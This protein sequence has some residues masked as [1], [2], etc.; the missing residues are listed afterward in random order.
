MP[1]FPINSRPNLPVYVH[2]D[3]DV[4]PDR[5]IEINYGLGLGE[6]IYVA[7]S[8]NN[9]TVVHCS[10]VTY[11]CWYKRNKMNLN[12]WKIQAILEFTDDLG[13]AVKVVCYPFGCKGYNFYT[14][15]IQYY[16][17]SVRY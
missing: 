2:A 5:I 17:W 15:D 8:G 3:A 16:N 7:F 1:Y 10:K 9:Y 12:T 13:R 4:A 6:H 14:Q 11:N